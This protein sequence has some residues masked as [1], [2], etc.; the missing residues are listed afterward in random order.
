MPKTFFLPCLPARNVIKE[1]QL[2][3]EDLDFIG[4]PGFKALRDLQ[5]HHLP[6]LETVRVN[7][8]FD[9]AHGERDAGQSLKLVDCIQNVIQR[10]LAKGREVQFN[11]CLHRYWVHPVT[12]EAFRYLAELSLSNV[13]ITF[14]GLSF[15]N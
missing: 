12:Q 13:F 3:I 4:S 7:V 9:R 5:P 15:S 2:I 14:N 8:S 1:L 10:F 11:I 6:S